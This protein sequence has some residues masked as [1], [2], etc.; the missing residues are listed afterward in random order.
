MLQLRLE[1]GNCRLFSIKSN[2]R[3]WCESIRILPKVQICENITSFSAI[4]KYGYVIKGFGT[5]MK[6][7]LNINYPY[8]IDMFK[9]RWY[10]G[11]CNPSYI[12]SAFSIEK[13][14]IG[15]HPL[16]FLIYN[17]HSSLNHRPVSN[18]NTL[19]QLDPL[20][21]MKSLDWWRAEHILG[22]SQ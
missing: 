4:E 12:K 5:Y 22:V 20:I 21:Q 11:I 2:I 6:P 17:L 1:A 18:Q 8:I 10:V 3:R 16:F 7:K 19:F 15:K 13:V 9:Y 14:L